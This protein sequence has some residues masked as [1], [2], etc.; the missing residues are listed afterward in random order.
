PDQTVVNTG[1]AVSSENDSNTAD[2]VAQHTL[3]LTGGTPSGGPTP[4]VLGAQT[5][6]GT[7]G[8]PAGGGSGSGTGGS[9]AAGGTG[10]GAAGGRV[11]G[12]SAGGILP[13]EAQALFGD[14]DSPIALPGLTAGC[15]L[16]LW[17]LILLEAIVALLAWQ[18]ERKSR[19]PWRR[20]TWLVSVA[21][22]AVPLILWWGACWLIWWLTAVIILTVIFLVLVQPEHE[23]VPP[24]EPPPAA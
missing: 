6:G 20:R 1:S 2:N 23:P 21:L 17:W 22:A 5:G 16:N 4:V 15:T 24:S 19:E 9:G 13:A 11:E 12:I 14:G 8:P 7:G 18:H 10:D 3:N